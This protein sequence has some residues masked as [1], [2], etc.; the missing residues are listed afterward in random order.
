MSFEEYIGLCGLNDL[1]LQISNTENSVTGRYD[2]GIIN[3]VFTLISVFF[4]I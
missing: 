1:S 4:A 2:L 3:R